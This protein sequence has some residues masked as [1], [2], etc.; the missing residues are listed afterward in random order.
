[1]YLVYRYLTAMYIIIHV[2]INTTTISQVHVG[3][4]SENHYGHD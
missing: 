3:M 1:M 4:M 2:D